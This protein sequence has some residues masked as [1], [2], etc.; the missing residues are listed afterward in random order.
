MLEKPKRSI[1]LIA[2]REIRDHLQSQRFYICTAALAVL[3]GF[4]IFV[5]FQDYVVR[6]ENYAVLQERARPRPGEMGLMAVVRPRVLSV[7]AKGL[8]ET[9][10]RGYT[11]TNFLGIEA[12]QRQTS[13]R[14]LFSLFPTPDLLH[15]IKVFLSLLA[16]VFSYN[17]ISGDRENGTL[18][19]LLS[20]SASRAQILAGKILGVLAVVLVP[21]FAFFLVGLTVLYGSGRL[22][23]D[24]DAFEKIGLM[25][26]ATVLYVFIFTCLGTLLSSLCRSSTTSLVT[27]LFLW[28]GVVLVY[29]NLGNLVAEQFVDVP[30]ASTQEAVRMSAFAK[31]RFLAIHS[32]DSGAGGSLA[33]FDAFY[34]GFLEAQ[35]LKLEE[36]IRTSR[37]ICEV[38]PAGTLT[39]IL[40]DLASTGAEEQMRLARQ[41]RTFQIENRD[42]LMD[43]LTGQR[44]HTPTVFNFEPEGTETILE[45]GVLADLGVLAL[46]GLLLLSASGAA[47]LRLDPR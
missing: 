30:S 42:F 24:S 26:A 8:E 3:V 7:F 23:L 44:G 40:T 38:S 15:V 20:S 22:A 31:N 11:V 5:M 39:F 14:S 28:G 21:F 27:L 35:R 46:I 45:Q 1:W 9:L 33:D 25:M 16:V 6:R 19:L 47:F 36:L 2:R 41:L 12:H 29:P 4:S 34:E 43:Q 17:A 37:R 10:D 18:R 32:K 13:V